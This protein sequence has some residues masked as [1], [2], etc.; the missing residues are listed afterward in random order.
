MYTTSK[1]W[2][3]APQLVKYPEEGGSVINTTLKYYFD[4]IALLNFTCTPIVYTKS[5]KDE[6]QWIL[7]HRIKCKINETVL[8]P[9]QI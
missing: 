6:V 9:Q 8:H 2:H 5:L 3:H 4:Y 7:D 1:H